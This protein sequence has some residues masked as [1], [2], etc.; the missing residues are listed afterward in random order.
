MSKGFTPRKRFSQNFLTDPATARKIVNA[1]EISPHDIVLEIGP[2]TG[3]LTRWLAESP[4]ST[5]HAWDVDQRAIDHCRAQP[6]G[7]RIVWHLA[8]VR[9]VRPE[10]LIQNPIAH[11]GLLVGNLPY[12]ITSDLIFWYLEHRSAFRR[13]V[14]MVQREVARRLVAR[15]GTKD[16]GALSVAVWQGAEAH[17]AF[18]VSPGAFYPKPEVT[19][20]VVVINTRQ[21]PVTAAPYAP[22]Q[23]FVRA[24]FSQRRKVMSNSLRPWAAQQG[25]QLQDS[26]FDL[27]K[28][29]AEQLEPEQLADLFLRLTVDNYL[30]TEGL[31]RQSV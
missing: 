6:W 17:I 7:H 13:A 19:S 11:P 25:V 28:V 5:I 18:Q 10:A 1:L 3:A 4:A 26:V 30:P 12:S 2:G 8:D 29:R 24:A 27:S 16:Y 20:S 14:I 31:E 22:F 9:T 21:K 15:P 23:Q